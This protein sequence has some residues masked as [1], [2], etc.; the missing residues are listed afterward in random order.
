MDDEKVYE[1]ILDN[2]I[3]IEYS[4]IKIRE[5]Q[6]KIFDNIDGYLQDLVSNCELSDELTGSYNFKKSDTK[7]YKKNWVKKGDK[8]SKIFFY[9]QGNNKEEFSPEF[10]LTH[11]LGLEGATFGI[12][13][14]HEAKNF[15]Q[16]QQADINNFNEKIKKVIKSAKK[17][18]L[19]SEDLG[20][21]LYIPIKLTNAHLLNLI[22]FKKNAGMNI[23]PINEAFEKMIEII[24]VI[25]KFL[26]DIKK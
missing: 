18:E 13:I 5:I 3:N 12:Y 24:P 2:I 20:H 14:G 9:I 23:E 11:M 7:I 15:P 25:D 22:S 4:I 19:V 16:N 1:L 17:S 8:N 21:Y 26:N 6:D 10:W